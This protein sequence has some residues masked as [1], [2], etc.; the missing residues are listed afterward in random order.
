M[1]KVCLITTFWQVRLCMCFDEVCMYFECGNI[2]Y[3]A[4]LLLLAVGY[5]LFK[6]C[7]ITICC[8]GCVC[9]CDGVCALLS[10]DPACCQVVALKQVC[11]I[12]FCWPVRMLY[13]VCVCVCDCVCAVEGA[14]VYVMVY[15]LSSF[16]LLL[17]LSICSQTGL[18]DRILLAGAYVVCCVCLCICWCLCCRG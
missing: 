3:L 4:P 10:P 15:V 17:V 7:L 8:R 6:A 2:Y 11:Q 5:F 12:T 1:F 9:V 14:S 18:P 13:I 16:L